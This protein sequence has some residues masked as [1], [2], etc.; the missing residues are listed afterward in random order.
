MS[1][2]IVQGKPETLTLGLG[3]MN[4]IVTLIS[5]V[6]ILW[7]LSGP[8][9][10]PVAGGIV[11]EGYLVWCAVLYA[12]FG[13]GATLSAV[14]ITPT[15]IRELRISILLVTVIIPDLAC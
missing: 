8:I 14:T 1:L 10:L 7:T 9:T 4:S 11:I 12:V 2:R 3:L 5:F 15:V 6:F 13:A